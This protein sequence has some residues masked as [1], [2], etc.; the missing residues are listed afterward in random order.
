MPAS[1]NTAYKW[2]FA[3]KGTLTRAERETIDSVRASGSSTHPNGEDEFAL[4]GPT[5]SSIGVSDGSFRAPRG[6]TFPRPGDLTLAQE[7][8]ESAR[9]T[10][11]SVQRKRARV[12][13]R[14]RVDEML[15]PKPMGREGQL[16][17][18][19]ARRESDRATRDQKDDAIGDWDESVLMGSGDADSFQAR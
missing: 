19:R 3:T 8:A 16:E 7:S 5:P 15:G 9:L 17:K 10:E 18:K 6:P 4:S 1:S 11:L 2:S 12:E 13:E 14:E